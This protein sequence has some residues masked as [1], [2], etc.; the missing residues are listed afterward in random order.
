MATQDKRWMEI[1]CT[2]CSF[3]TGDI[4]IRILFR[5]I[6]IASVRPFTRKEKADEITSPHE[7]KITP[8]WHQPVKIHWDQWPWN[9]FAMES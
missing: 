6:T 5:D 3:F 2:S 8:C 7:R 9:Q 1:S 4:T